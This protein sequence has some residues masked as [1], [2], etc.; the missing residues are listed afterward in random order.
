MNNQSEDNSTPKLPVMESPARYRIRVRGHLDSSWSDRM[1]GMSITTT[2][3]K[4]TEQITLLEGELMDQVA[5]TGVIN[6]LNDLGLPL[7]AVECIDSL[8][9]RVTRE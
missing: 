9:G 2:G 7:L 4:N 6:T 3:G 8:V 5:L 1:A